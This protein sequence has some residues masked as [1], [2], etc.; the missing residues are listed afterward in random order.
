MAAHYP[1]LSSSSCTVSPGSVDPMLTTPET[2]AKK[3]RRNHM[4]RSDLENTRDMSSPSWMSSHHDNANHV[5]S[6]SSF[7]IRE[8]DLPI[9]PDF[10]SRPPRKW[11]SSTEVS[12]GILGQYNM[13]TS[14]ASYAIT[15]ASAAVTP[16]PSSSTKKRRKSEG[17]VSKEREEISKMFVINLPSQS[18]SDS[19]VDTRYS[20]ATSVTPMA[21]Q[22]NSHSV[23]KSSSL[24]PVLPPNNEIRLNSLTS[25]SNMVTP[26]LGLNKSINPSSNNSN[27][28]KAAD[29]H[30]DPS[31]NP[32]MQLAL[33]SS[34]S[35]QSPERADLPSNK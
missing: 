3:S 26:R 10:A 20:L 18:S 4:I 22:D 29:W 31:V 8:M 6:S 27:C 30:W 19:Y 11:R 25:P 21:S 16:L 7:E 1:L 13:G 32:L 35:S 5:P 2:K 24:S 28:D 14:T 34:S 17:E 12:S 15:A 23:Q 9:R 33:L